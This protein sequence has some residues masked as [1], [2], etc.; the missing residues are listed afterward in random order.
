MKKAALPSVKRESRPK[1]RRAST[2]TNTNSAFDSSRDW[3][4]TYEG[5]PNTS[6]TDVKIEGAT[7]I[8]TLQRDDPATAPTSFTRR[9]SRLD[10]VV[11]RRGSLAYLSKPLHREVCGHSPDPSR[12]HRGLSSFVNPKSNTSTTTSSNNNLATETEIESENE[13]E[14]ERNPSLPHPSS[15]SGQSLRARVEDSLELCP[16]VFAIGSLTGDSLIRFAYGSC[17]YAAA[18]IMA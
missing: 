11:G 1:V 13:N 4:T 10:Y 3:S 18:R 6:I 16:N 17:V 7:A 9:I 15:I 12:S 14:C 8:I 5:L 2:T